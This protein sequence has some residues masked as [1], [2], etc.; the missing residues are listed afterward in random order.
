[1]RQALEATFSGR[2]THALPL[3][4]PDPPSS[5]SAPFPR[6]AE[7]VGL[8]YGTLSK[9]G[10]AARRFLDPMLRGEAVGA[11]DPVLW[12]CQRPAATEGPPAWNA[13][14][15]PQAGSPGQA[16]RSWLGFSTTA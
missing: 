1:M 14:A 16:H 9:A 2:R 3:H 5:W 6:L 12:S 8:D 10:E 15:G 13:S 4:L 7:D 11:W